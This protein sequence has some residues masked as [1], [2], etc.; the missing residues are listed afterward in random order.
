M[1]VNLVKLRDEFPQQLI[2][3]NPSKNVGGYLE[4]GYII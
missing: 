1:L 4:V 3:S 2:F